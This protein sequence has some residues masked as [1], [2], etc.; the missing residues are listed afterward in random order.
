MDNA[1]GMCYGEC[2][3][4]TIHRPV[5]LPLEQIIHCMLI[6]IIKKKRIIHSFRSKGISNSLL[7][8]RNNHF[9]FTKSLAY[10]Q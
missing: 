2:C 6:T 5:S 9:M 4:M 1:D 10:K 8:T 7:F 3:E